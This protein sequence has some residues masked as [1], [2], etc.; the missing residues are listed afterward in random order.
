M[1]NPKLIGAICGL[2]VGLVVI[3]V[4]VLEGFVLALFILAGW[5]AGKLWMHEVDLISLYHQFKNKR[6][7][8][9]R[10]RF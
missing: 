2:I 8:K 1:T 3:L 4:G 6:A 10:E 5:F 7:E 9:R